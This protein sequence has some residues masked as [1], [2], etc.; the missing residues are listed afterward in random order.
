MTLTKQNTDMTKMLAE[1]PQH[2]YDTDDALT[3]KAALQERLRVS[4]NAEDL[5]RQRI[6]DQRYDD[7]GNDLFM[8]AWLMLKIESD[9][10]PNLLT[11]KGKEKV[12]RRYISALMLEEESSPLLTAERA[13]FARTLI[14]IFCTSRSYSTTAFGL[15]TMKDEW[16]ANRIASEIDAVTRLY[17]SLFHAEDIFLPLREELIKAY[18]TMIEHG[19]EYWKTYIEN[20]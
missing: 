17:P 3:R 12:L 10:K 5:E 11:R 13:H 14:R 4:E 1:W 2:F 8:Q 7:K 6:L 20:N 16:T 15:M 19:S 9:T 18:T